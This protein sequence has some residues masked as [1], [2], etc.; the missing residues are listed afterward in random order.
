MDFIMTFLH[1][2]IILFAHICLSVP[3]PCPQFLM[4]HKV[5]F[6]QQASYRP[7]YLYMSYQRSMSFNGNPGLQLMMVCPHPGFICPKGITGMQTVSNREVGVGTERD[8]VASTLCVR[9]N[10]KLFKRI[11]SAN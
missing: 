6:R 9:A 3:F 7:L 5:C 4:L 8:S 1:T 10:L 11:K 2:H